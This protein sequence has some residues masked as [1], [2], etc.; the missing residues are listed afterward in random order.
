MP[1]SLHPPARQGVYPAAFKVLEEQRGFSVQELALIGTFEKV[2][3]AVSAVFFGIISDKIPKF[4]V[5]SC[6][7]LVWTLTAIPM[8]FVTT[9][10]Q[11]LIISVLGGLVAGCLPPLSAV[12]IAQLVPRQDRGKYFG[13]ALFC[14]QL[15]TM[16][17][18][19]TMIS[20]QRMT[21]PFGLQGWQ[22]C[23]LGLSVLCLAFTVLI[24]VFAMSDQCPALNSSDSPLSTTR[25]SDVC[26][27]MFKILSIPSV[28]VILL[29]GLFRNSSVQVL[30]FTAM[31]IQYQGF[32]DV[33]AAFMNDARLTA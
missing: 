25:I 32:S 26:K 4:T 2:A 9:F 7:S 1:L 29:Q 24:A 31:W 13:F 22:M 17:G 14:E 8:A 6:V 18:Q 23:F 33:D 28:L 20:I 10:S 21:G 19:T 5:L 3:F 11:L 27:N 12:I 16:I 30:T 15:G